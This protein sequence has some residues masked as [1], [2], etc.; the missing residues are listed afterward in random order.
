MRKS[1][2]LAL[3]VALIIGITSLTASVSASTP[4][5]VEVDNAALNMDVAPVLENSRVLVPFRFIAESL[6]G[7]VSWNGDTQTVGIVTA[8]KNIS[9]P[10]GKTTATVNGQTQQLDVP[11]KII[12]GRTLVPDRFVS[13]SLGADVSWDDAKQTVI[14]KYF[15]T[16]TGTLK[17]GGSTTVQPVTQ[18]AA[19]Y[20]TKIS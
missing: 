18:A 10:V 5:K 3:V 8:D 7:I 14:V 1:K 16:M 9:L 2:V 13:E 19:D 4:I 11:A 12:N 17:V 15:S 20:L 6:G